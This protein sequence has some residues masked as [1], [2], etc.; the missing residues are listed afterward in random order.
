MLESIL[1]Q[2]EEHAGRPR[3][4]ARGLAERLI[5]GRTTRGQRTTCMNRG[6][7]SESSRRALLRAPKNCRPCPPTCCGWTESGALGARQGTARRARRTDHRREDGHVVAVSA[8]ERRRW[9]RRCREKL[10]S[11]MQMLNQA[12]DAQAARG[13]R[14]AALAARS[15]RPRGG[16]CAAISTSTAARAGIECVATLPDE[17]LDLDRGDAAQRCFASRRRRWRTSSRAAAPSMSRW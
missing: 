13:R 16:A 15:F 1:A 8:P 7:V 17:A 12:D 5:I 11:V 4:S 3:R 10:D 14:P 9:T 6:N 2:E